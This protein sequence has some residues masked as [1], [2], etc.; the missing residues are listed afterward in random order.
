MR[1]HRRPRRVVRQPGRV[2]L[3]H[4]AAHPIHR[5]RSAA[6]I[7]SP[8]VRHHR[9]GS[10][11]RRGVRVGELLDR[12]LLVGEERIGAG[13]PFGSACCRVD[14][15]HRAD[16]VCADGRFRVEIPGDRRAGQSSTTTRPDRRSRRTVAPTSCELGRRPIRRASRGIRPNAKG[17]CGRLRRSRAATWRRPTPPRHASASCSCRIRRRHRGRPGRRRRRRRI[18]TVRAAGGAR[19]ARLAIVFATCDRED[20]GADHEDGHRSSGHRDPPASRRRRWRRKRNGVL[21]VTDPRRQPSDTVVELIRREV[22]V[23]DPLQDVLEGRR[24]HALLE[25]DRNDPRRVG[26]Q[27]QLTPDVLGFRRVR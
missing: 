17:R 5:W 1:P 11:A 9:S 13:G 3:V 19:T 24:L 6:G 20:G 12:D 8:R 15:P 10:G 23:L 2:V 18:A 14:D 27:L 7:A 4:E 21:P 16:Q 22:D 26:R 25:Q